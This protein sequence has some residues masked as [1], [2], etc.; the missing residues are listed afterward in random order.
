MSNRSQTRIAIVGAGLVGQQHAR[1]V[2]R[3]ATL[4][5]IVDPADQARQLAGAYNTRYFTDLA[6]LLERARPDGIILAS[7]TPLHYNQAMACIAA[8]VPTLVEKPVTHDVEDGQSLVRAAGQANVALLV[9]HHR[10]YS[11]V[12]AA[13]RE[14]ISSGRLGNIVSAHASCWL[15]KP[16]EYFDVPWRRQPGAGPILTNLIH[17]VDLLRHLCGD[18][19]FVQASCSSSQRGLDIEDSAVV[20]M[21]F[22]NGALGTMTL[23]DTI[24]SP[25]SWEL[26]AGENPAYPRTREASYQIG[27]TQAS[28]SLPNLALWHYGQSAGW[29]EP[30][31]AETQAVQTDGITD[32][33]ARQVIHFCDVIAGVAEPVVSGAEGLATLRV[34]NAIELASVNHGR[35]DLPTAPGT[36]GKCPP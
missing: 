1:Q 19:S 16:D 15:L 34:I 20:I 12:I 21:G 10:R 2:A 30:I 11:P 4:H 29:W 9:G 27:G 25:W 28:L 18:I 23:S 8:G 17:D 26:T 36:T 24:V 13:A 35:V 22:A 7:P 32:P 33:L 14:I 6:D 5:A 3:E 31:A